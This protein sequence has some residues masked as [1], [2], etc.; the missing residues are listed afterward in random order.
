MVLFFIV[1]ILVAI[2]LAYL[3][4]LVTVD[5]K[6][7]GFIRFVAIVGLIIWAAVLFVPLI[8]GLA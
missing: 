7:W 5:A 4:S 8:R 1:A 2:A 3:P 6:V